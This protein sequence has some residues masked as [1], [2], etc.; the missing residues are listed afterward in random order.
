[1]RN[2][3]KWTSLLLTLLNFTI[4]NAQNLKMYVSDA[5]N[6]N[7]P[8][9]QILKFDANG[10]NGEVFISNHLDWPQDILF[11]E[12]DNVVLISNLNS[13]EIL[14]F[15]ATSGAYI[16]AFATGIDGPTRMKIGKDSLLY[17][18][19]WNGAGIILRYDLKAHLSISF[20][21]L[22]L[23]RVLDWIGTRQGISM[24]L[25][26]MENLCKNLIPRVQVLVNSSAAI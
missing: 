18:L 16:N 20:R 13:G 21:P 7:L 2:T 25:L 9:W 14:R 11:L 12:K 15:N 22:G 6:F 17:V 23:T 1:M 26:I 5:G 4:V 3:L 19:E 8:P 10:D 24:S